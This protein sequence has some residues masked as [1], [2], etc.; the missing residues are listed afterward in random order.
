M[1]GEPLPPNY[2]WRREG[3]SNLYYLALDGKILTYSGGENSEIL[4]FHRTVNEGQEQIDFA[5]PPN[6]YNWDFESVEGTWT[7]PETDVFV[8][9]YNGNVITLDISNWPAFV[10]TPY[11]TK[12][13]EPLPPKN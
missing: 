13:G 2:E 9:E 1:K 4:T 8:T 7:E 5:S 3:E 10:M 12:I 11:V 6:P